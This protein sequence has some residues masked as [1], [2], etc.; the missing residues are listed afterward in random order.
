MLWNKVNIE[1]GAYGKIIYKSVL[2]EYKNCFYEMISNDNSFEAKANA[3]KRYAE[4]IIDI[5]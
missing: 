1:G 5:F 4:M 3:S 2:L